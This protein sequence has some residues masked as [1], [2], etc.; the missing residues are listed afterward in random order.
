MGEEFTLGN[1]SGSDFG[2]KSCVEKW[3]GSIRG[4]PK[5]DEEDTLVKDK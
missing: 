2:C 5:L 1:M 3:Y 4:T